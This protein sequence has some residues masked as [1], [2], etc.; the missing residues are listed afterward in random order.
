M[1]VLALALPAA[2]AQT[3]I[4]IS[5]EDVIVP[6]GVLDGGR[7]WYSAGGRIQ[8]VRGWTGEYETTGGEY[9]DGTSI[10][11]ANWNLDL[12]SGDGT[13]WGTTDLTLTG[14]NGGWHETWVAKFDD[15]VWSGWAVGRGFG[16]LQ[17]MKIRLDVWSTG[18]GLD[19]FEGFV[20]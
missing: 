20:R 1:L 15:F 7:E 19:E 9:V 14:T 5:G 10:V 3:K 4:P 17:G 6:N 12:A 18:E 13:M 2:A 16:D 11:V 8:H